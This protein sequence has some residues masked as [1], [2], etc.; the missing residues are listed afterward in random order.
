[1]PLDMPVHELI[2]KF[3]YPWTIPNA[4]NSDDGWFH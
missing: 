2:D 1:M 4:E 3:Y